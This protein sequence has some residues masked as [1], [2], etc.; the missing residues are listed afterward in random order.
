[1]KLKLSIL[2][3]GLSLITQ[4]QNSIIGTITNTNNE[5]LFGVEIY[6]PKLHKGTTS[7]EDGSYTFKNLPKGSIEIV[8][9]YIGYTSVIKTIVL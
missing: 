8:F 6:A 3:I 1:M 5:Q 2:F 7:N 4:A 9:S